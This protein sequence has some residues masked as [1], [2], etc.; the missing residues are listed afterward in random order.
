LTPDNANGPYYVLGES[1]HSNVVESE[2]GV[3]LHL[4]MK[5]VDMTTCLPATNLF[6]D[7]WSCN[8]LGVY[9]GVSASGEGGL[10]TTFLRGVQQ[11]DSDGVVVFDTIF[12]GHYSGRA[13]HEHVIAH[14]GAA[15]KANGTYS[16]GHISHLS[17]LFWDQDLITRAEATSPYNTNTIPKTSNN[18]DLFTG[19]SA[20]ASYDPF[21]EYI[22]VGGTPDLSKRLFAWIEIGIRPSADYTNYGTNSCI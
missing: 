11:T 21:L 1:I 15:L 2:V 10:D 22:L 5:F 9:S 3:P 18:A 17:Q 16:G 12:P 20:S 14:S 13:S 19:Y 6:I 7:I 8:A 4:D